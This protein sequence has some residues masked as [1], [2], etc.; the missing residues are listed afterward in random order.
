MLNTDE[1]WD[2]GYGLRDMLMKAIRTK[3]V[4]PRR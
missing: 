4:Q 2:R 1:F 3:F